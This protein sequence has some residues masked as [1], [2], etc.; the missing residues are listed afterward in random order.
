MNTSRKQ[1][2]ATEEPTAVHP[3][4]ASSID[5]GSLAGQVALVTG[6]TSGI[7]R[8]IATAFSAAGASVVINSVNS[9]ASGQEIAKA[10]PGALY[11]Q[12]DISQEV[13]RRRLLDTTLEQ[14]G[15]LD[16]LI[17][18]AGTTSVVPHSDLDR[19]SDELFQRILDVNLLGTWSLSRAALPYLKA[20]G[21][22]ILNVTSIAGIRPVGSSI[23]YAVSKAALNHL[24]LRLA[25]VVG[26]TVRVNALAPGLIATPWTE[27]WNAQHKSV[28]NV[29]PLARSGTPEDVAYAALVLTL[30]PYVTGQILV[31]DGG[32][33][34]KV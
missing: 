15:R 24:T 7:G 20:Q 21:G 4:P 12:A 28:A 14:F 6:S 18:N 16:H 5:A 13:D 11:V 33:T 17:N 26:P 31:A 25:K 23:P 19:V 34:L 3:T 8:A 9:R 2:P 1:E 30:S 29:A 27:G 10:L 22:T 32:L